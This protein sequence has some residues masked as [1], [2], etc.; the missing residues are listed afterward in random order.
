MTSQSIP[1]DK[2]LYN[3]LREYCDHCGIRFIDFIEEALE[4]AV[5]REE[6]L[7]RSEK[8]DVVLERVDSNMRRSFRRGFWRGFCVGI[9]ASQ[10][11]FG[12]CERI[13][14]SKVSYKDEPF[15]IVTGPQ[16]KLF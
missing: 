2:E 1:I 5:D 12:L 7:K 3:N 6:I 8:A 14:P 10:G 4:N 15:K 9:L 16:L 11:R 13:T